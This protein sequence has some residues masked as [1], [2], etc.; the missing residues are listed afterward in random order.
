[1]REFDPFHS[2]QRGFFGFSPPFLNIQYFRPS[3]QELMRV[4][5]CLSSMEYLKVSLD[6]QAESV[7]ETQQTKTDQELNAKNGTSSVVQPQQTS[8]QSS[9]DLMLAAIRNGDLPS[10][11]KLFREN[12]ERPI[13]TDANDIYSLL[14]EAVVT[15]DSSLVSYLLQQSIDINEVTPS[16]K[17]YT[18]LHIGNDSIFLVIHS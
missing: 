18:P 2:Q 6:P 16:L 11:E 4:H 12:Y 13:P 15:S 7:Q 3:L 9:P 17:F 8:L 10:L 1:M 14:T 5:Q